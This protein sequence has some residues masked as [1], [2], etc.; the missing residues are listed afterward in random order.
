MYSLVIVWSY[1]ANSSELL[2]KS[3]TSNRSNEWLSFPNSCIR[4]KPLT[5]TKNLSKTTD[6]TNIKSRALLIRQLFQT[7]N[8]II[9][10][11]RTCGHLYLGSGCRNH[12][13]SSRNEE[14]EEQI[15]M[16][17]DFGCFQYFLWVK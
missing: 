6:V 1:F 14:A 17:D 5:N 7:F 9:F 15:P 3:Y 2:F 11:N 12:Q 4:Q 10:S 13:L 8:R 16:V